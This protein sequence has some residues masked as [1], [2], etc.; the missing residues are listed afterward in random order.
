[1]PNAYLFNASGVSISVSINNGAFLSVSPADSTSWVP[2]TP[3]A[4]PTFVNNTNPGNGQLGLG[5]NTI[6]LYPSTSGPAS[7]VNFTLNIPTEVTVSSL[8][9]YLFWK[10]AK[11]VAFAALNGG[12]FIQV[13]S[14]AFS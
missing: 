7:S 10:D 13:D 2:S 3:A 5:P 9:L 4:Q 1:M 6:T 14:A 12:Q 8:Q 11:N